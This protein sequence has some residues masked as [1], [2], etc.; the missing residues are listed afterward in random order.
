MELLLV[1]LIGPFH[2]RSP[3]YNGVSVRDALAAW[4]PDALA[5]SA[6]ARGEMAEP[7]WQD[8]PE[9]ALPLAVAPWAGR[10]GLPLR[11]FGE[12]SPEPG[13]EDDFRRYVE[14]FPE[15]RARLAKVEA[16]L[17]PVEALLE[18]GLTAERITGA[19]LPEIRAHQVA[20][21]AEFGDGPATDWLRQRMETVAGRVFDLAGEADDLRLAVLAPVDHLPFLED[22]LRAG[23][24][25]SA[26]LPAIARSP[27]ALERS[28]L[29]YAFRVDVPEPA[30]LLERL[31]EMAGSEARYHEANLLLAGGHGYEA[32]ELLEKTS[33]GDFSSPYFLPGYLLARLGQLRDLADRRDDALRAYRGA[34]ALDFAPAEA[35]EAA[36][37]GLERP[38]SP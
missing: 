28:V 23:G 38:F 33:R 11:E 12:P 31:R 21:E 37:A 16:A 18:E 34:L 25:E 22:A 14:P 30:S 8:T 10:R 17:R 1:P 4:E 2:L 35:R 19:L 15:L 9:I 7:R 29:D 20:R 32:L 5:T 27:E 26:R 6:L 13:S 3:S 24:L 36:R